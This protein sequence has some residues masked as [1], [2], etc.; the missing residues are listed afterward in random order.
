MIEYSKMPGIRGIGGE[1]VFRA[2][3]D[4]LYLTTCQPTLPQ[5]AESTPTDT[6]AVYAR[7]TGR[8]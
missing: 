3:G 1:S 6:E 4:A 2:A 5:Q 8:P 7:D